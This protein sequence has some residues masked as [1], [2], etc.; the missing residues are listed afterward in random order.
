LQFSCLSINQDILDQ[1]INYASRINKFVNSGFGYWFD[2]E[3]IYGSDIL[4]Q[5]GE[6]I[7][8]N[9]CRNRLNEAYLRI[10]LNT[11]DISLYGQ[12]YNE[13]PV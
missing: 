6:I 4:F 8:T 13:K 3:K 9:I 1:D 11:I 7:G 10:E 12:K 5:F 2:K